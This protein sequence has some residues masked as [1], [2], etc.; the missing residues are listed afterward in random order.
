[1]ASGL[2]IPGKVFQPSLKFA[3][4]ARSLP[5]KYN[6]VHLCGLRPYAKIV[7]LSQKRLPQPNTLAYQVATSKTNR[8]GFTIL[9]PVACMIVDQ[10]HND[11]LQFVA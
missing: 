3:S 2:F 7:A 8:N 11:T 10:K 4:K 6:M 9:K 5:I 1:M